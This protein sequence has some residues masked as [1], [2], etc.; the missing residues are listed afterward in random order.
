MKWKLFE[1]V[2]GIGALRVGLVVL[3]WMTLYLT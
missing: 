2:L 3:Y 1:G